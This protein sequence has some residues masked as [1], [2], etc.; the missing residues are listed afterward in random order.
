M[1]AKSFCTLILGGILAASVGVS[2]SA[3]IMVSPPDSKAGVTQKYELRVHNEETLAITSVDL[4]IPDGIS[5]L[6]IGPAPSGTYTT[7]KTGDRIT[8]LT[9][10]VDVA[11]SKYLALPF[12]AKN[13]DSARDVSWNATGW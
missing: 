8:S 13:P 10:K 12:T 7:A 3:H 11:A 6:T 2:L 1:N 4:T 9:W 5:V